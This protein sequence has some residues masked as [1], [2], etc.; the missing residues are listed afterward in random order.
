MIRRLGL[1]AM[2]MALAAACSG[3]GG[4]AVSTSTKSRP[5]SPQT[6]VG[7]LPDDGAPAQVREVLSRG[8]GPLS[9]G[10]CLTGAKG[11]LEVVIAEM[12]KR[13]ETLAAECDH[14]ALF[15][16]EYLLTT[17]EVT[18]AVE[19]GEFENP[20][21]IRML[22]AVYA[23]IYFDR[24]DAWTEGRRAEVPS[25]WASAFAAADA[26]S[27]TGIGDVLSA[28][29]GHITYDL[30]IALTTVGLP[31]SE[32][33]FRHINDLIAGATPTV[34]A[35]IAARFDPDLSAFSVPALD[36]DE[37]SIAGVFTLW[38]EEALVNAKRLA[39]AEDED[40]VLREIT[41]IA[42]SRALAAVAGT[43]YVPFVTNSDAR[44]AFCEAAA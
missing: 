31:A 2:L 39:A 6:T 9:N 44:D 27:L 8:L 42:D 24:R 3:D 18:A 13:F 4:R 20:E 34:I 23:Q 17:K 30:P 33:D 32:N 22:D 29:N 15:A 37:Q 40:R 7:R 14:N 19:G 21:Y 38:R 12:T 16:L 1:I 26:R 35:E 11:C 36:I 10:L 43:A 25:P 28:S 41:A 5:S